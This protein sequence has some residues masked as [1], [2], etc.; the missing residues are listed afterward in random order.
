MRTMET[1]PRSSR[2]RPSALC[3]GLL[4]LVL[5]TATTACDIRKRMYDQPRVEPLEKSDF[6]ADGS[7]ARSLVEG[8]VARGHL[9]EDE[10]FHTGRVDGVFAETFP[11]EITKDVL[12]RG[13]SRFNIYCAT[14]HDRAGTGNGMIVKR[15]YKQPPS[16]HID[17]LKE[18][19]PGYYFHV[20]TQGFGV[21][22]NYRYQL[23]PEDRWAVAAYIQALQLSQSATLDDVPEA[24]RAS[25]KSEVHP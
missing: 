9:N 21:M 10:H 22:P 19:A 1:F 12:K 23:N 14:C 16:M 13:Q 4:A 6:F 5:L 20:M 7:T 17:R 11:M 25:L 15:G 8:T 24:Q 3:A 2:I 18:S